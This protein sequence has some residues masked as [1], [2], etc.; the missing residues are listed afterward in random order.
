MHACTYDTFMHLQSYEYVF[1]HVCVYFWLADSVADWRSLSL[2]DI[3]GVA[4]PLFWTSL[5][6]LTF[7]YLVLRENDRP[8]RYTVPS[9]KLPEKFEILDEPAIKVCYLSQI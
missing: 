3:S 4:W 6:A 9:P 8:I 2:D 5:G 7:L 1:T